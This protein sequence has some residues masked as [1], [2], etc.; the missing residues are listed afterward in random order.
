VDGRGRRSGALWRILPVMLAAAATLTAGPALA[1]PASPTPAS[2]S[3]P[4]GAASAASGV[5]LPKDEG[6]HKDAVEWWYFNG[7]LSGRDAAG[8]LHSYGFEYVT[9]QF[10]LFGPSPMYVA[11][12]AV[13]DLDRKSFQFDAVTSST[14]EPATTGRFALTTG[15]WSMSGASGSDTLHASMRHYAIDLVTRALEPAALEGP[16][17]VVDLGP[18]GTADYYSWTALATS[19]TVVDHGDVVHV[20]GLSW[21]D[22]EW[23]NT[24]SGAAGW[25]WFSVQLNDGEQLMVELVRTKAGAL[26]D[27]SGTLVRRSGVSYLASS[28]VAERALGSWTSPVTHI[29]YGSGWQLSVPGGHLTV[30]PDVA[31]QEVDLRSVQG[32]VYWEGDCSVS[33]VLA[34][35]PVS[36][37]GYTELNPPGQPGA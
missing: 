4:L 34:G 18:L 16:G 35:K 32:T 29:R 31:D 26:V 13:T 3:R 25:D 36:G 14:P 24:L 9:F 33:G 11:D 17:G 27:G 30:T 28:Q 37:V 1:A 20:T 15:S 5:T 7:H 21:M 8:K 23:S 10:R 19:G 6:A 12:L 22:H 2:A